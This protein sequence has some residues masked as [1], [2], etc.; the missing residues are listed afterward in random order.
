[1]KT[2]TA[3]P[4]DCYD[5][6]SVIVEG[7]K[8]KGAGHPYTNGYL[9]PHLNHYHKYPCITQPLLQGEPVTMDAA[10][11]HLKTRL[12]AALK[13]RGVLHYRSSGNFGLMQGVTDHFFASIGATLTEGSLCDGAGE[14]GIIAGRGA[15]HVLPPEQIARSE[16]VVVWGRNIPVTNAHLVLFMRDKTM[17]VVDP[18]RTKL[19]DK[20]QVH[21]QIKPGGDLHLAILLTR[22]AI[23]A[24]MH[25]VAYLTRVAPGFEA[26]HALIRSVDTHNALQTIGLKRG[27]IE[28]ILECLKGKKVTFLVGT[29]VQKYRHGDEVLR[30]IDALGAVLGLFGK[31]G[32]GV[33]YL[34]SSSSGIASPFA[35]AQRFV[36]KVTADFDAFDLVFIQ[37]ANPAAQMPDSA[38]VAMSLGRAGYIVYFGTY[39]NETSALADLVIPAKSFLNK[40]DVRVAYGHNAMLDMPPVSTGGKGISEYALAK[41]LCTAFDVPLESEAAY[42]LHF[43][44]F[45]DDTTD[46][47]LVSQ[48][49]AV[50]YEAG[51]ATPGGD[52]SFMSEYNFDLD[53]HAGMFLIT[54]KSPRSLNSQFRRE[55]HVYL[56]P[57]CGILEEAMVRVVSQTGEVV[58][59]LRHDDRL[60]CDCVLIHAG[61][62]GVNNLTPAV[63]SRAGGN[64]C[65]QS[66]KVKVEEC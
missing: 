7:G 20:A 52:F 34:G 31:P 11:Q 43:R 17:I 65:F 33:G 60:R 54:P 63:Q 66:N 25:D 14:A 58:L 29:G 44:S 32:C 6:C 36:S 45:R 39:E 56:H 42:L 35:K 12:G 53:M 18:V 2:L 64:A 19:A 50:P 62:A 57:S 15:N 49:E 55:T 8:L 27:D 9:C 41:R 10:L 16:V 61:T 30:A 26:Y 37:G 1:M 28:R 59:P 23:E 24:G 48:R 46:Q 3:C 40:A 38:R 47:G 22:Y 21:V 5:G 51:F 4:L 13:G